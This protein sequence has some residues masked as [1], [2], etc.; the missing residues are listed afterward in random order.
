[1][2]DLV[3]G[4]RGLGRHVDHE[5]GPLPNG[6]IADAAFGIVRE[7]LTNV[8]RHAPGAH[9]R[10]RCQYGDTRTDIVVTSS[11]PPTGATAHGANLGGGRGAAFLRSRARE[12]GGTLTSGPTADGGW[13]VA[14]VLPGRTAAP[15]KRS[16]PR[17]YRL[18]QLTAAAG[19]IL[20]PLLPVMI[21]RSEDVPSGSTVS[22]GAFFAL[23]A[24]AQAVALLWLRRAPRAATGA[25]IASAPLWP[26]A[27]AVGDYTGPVVLPPALSMLAT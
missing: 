19:L 26:V 27:M 9:T 1:M 4:F 21:I 15:V 10:V 17:G 3:E 12:T 6:T 18:A 22:A 20:Q 7:A 13:E 11:A 5:I 16:V 8:A 24:A 2:R 23:L 25:L 14:A